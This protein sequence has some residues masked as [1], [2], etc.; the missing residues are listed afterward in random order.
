MG[1]SWAGKHIIFHSDYLA[2]VHVVQNLNAADL[3]LG[4]LLRCLYFYAA[5]YHFTFTAA[6][7]P[8]PGVDNVAA[9]ALSC[10]N[11]ILFRSLFPQV[12]QHTIPHNLVELFLLDIPDL[13]SG[14]WMSRFRISLL[15]AS[16]LQP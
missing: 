11:M 9:D 8:I 16:L 7:I 10:D 15:P 13:N 6:H 4:N 1:P 12:P 3:R 14:A 5:H 2:V